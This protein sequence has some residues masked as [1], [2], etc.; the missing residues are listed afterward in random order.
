MRHVKWARW[1]YTALCICLLP[2]AF[3]AQT[4]GTYAGIGRTATSAE[5]AAWNIDVRPD[6]KGLP[7]GRGSVTQGQTVWDAQC[8]SC[9]GVFG[10]SNE[11]FNPIVGGTTKADVA[12]G[13]VKSLRDNSY[14]GRT[15]FMKLSQVSTL[16][17]Y[18]RRAMPWTHPKSLKVDEVYAVTA[19]L[20]NLADVVPSDFTLTQ[21]NMAQ[22]DRLLPNRD[23]LDRHHHLWPGK[24]FGDTGKPDVQ[25]SR[26]MHDCAGA[27]KVASF[28]PAYAMGAHG[29]LADQ[30][31]LVGPVRGLQT[32]DAAAAPAAPSSA[33]AATPAPAAAPTAAPTAAPMAAPTQTPGP[34]TVSALLSTHGCVTCHAVERKVV[35][36]AFRE[37]ARRY[38]T[39]AD[40]AAYFMGKIRSGGQGVWGTVPMPPQAV[41]EGDLRQLAQ[42]LADGAPD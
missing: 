1:A 24:E 19:Y 28:V 23:G 18:I 30:N 40:A 35:G 11:V 7:P 10:D 5:I 16:W 8:A 2:S 42:W 13:H 15:T 21:D 12:A 3:Y 31:R 34:A 25:G 26:C 4:N 22:V 38:S 33:P 39:R 9:H 36:P 37:I 17:D 41:A 32:P 6:F 29:N 14:P 27:P 20:L